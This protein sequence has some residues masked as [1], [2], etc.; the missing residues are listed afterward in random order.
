[1]SWPNSA[2][3]IRPWEVQAKKPA[4]AVAI[5]ETSEFRRGLPGAGL[6]S[7]VIRR[8]LPFSDWCSRVVGTRVP[9]EAYSYPSGP[10]AKRPPIVN[11]G[12]FEYRTQSPA[13]A[14]QLKRAMRLSEELV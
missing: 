10:N 3:N 8:I 5:A 7:A 9:V 12:F 6:P 4:H 13:A 14:H 11:T 1:V 2:A